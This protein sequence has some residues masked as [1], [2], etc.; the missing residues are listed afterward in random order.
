NDIRKL[1]DAFPSVD[2]VQQALVMQAPNILPVRGKP[3]TLAQLGGIRN[4]ELRRVLVAIYGVKA[5]GDALQRDDYGAL[6][7]VDDQ[8]DAVHVTCPS[9]GREY[10]L[11]VPATCETA[12][13]GV[14]WSFGLEHQ[15]AA[16][17]T[18]LKEA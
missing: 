4:A 7:V 15:N 18:L 9:T 5:H 11:G 13:A 3:R 8:T 1:Y 17:L 14:L 10:W 6:Y 2:I 16:H 12:R